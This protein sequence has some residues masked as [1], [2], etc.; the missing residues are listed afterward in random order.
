MV[1]EDLIKHE[2]TKYP[3]RSVV[4]KAEMREVAELGDRQACVI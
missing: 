2:S 1:R 4:R 3:H